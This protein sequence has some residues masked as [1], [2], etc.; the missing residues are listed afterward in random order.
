MGTWA[1]IASGPSLT[2]EQVEYIRQARSDGRI[3]GFIAVSNVALDFAPDADAIVSHDSKWWRVNS[4]AFDLKMRK[5]CRMVLSGTEHFIPRIKNGCNSG[6]MAMEVAHKI[7]GAD[8][9]I[10]LGFDMGG[11][12]YFGAHPDSLKNTTPLR[13]KEHIAQFIT[14]R[15][16]PVINCTP[17]SNL[18]AFP[19]IPLKDVL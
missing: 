12:H 16:C 4:K 13:F 1:V 5:F 19:L 17:N 10:I 8:R 3:D 18:K 11:T 6:L 15:G 9:I 2:G 7:Y 14:W